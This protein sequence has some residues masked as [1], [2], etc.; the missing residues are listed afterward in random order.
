MMSETNPARQSITSSLLMLFSDSIA[1]AMGLLDVNAP[2]GV[3]AEHVA[4]FATLPER[5]ELDELALEDLSPRHQELLH[6]LAAM[7]CG[8]CDTQSAPDP[9]S[10]THY[11]LPSFIVSCNNRQKPYLF[12]RMAAALLPPLTLC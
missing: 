9:R 2:F 5:N 11:E 3:L 4:V 7:V 8:V 1:Q 12:R 6:A 10:G